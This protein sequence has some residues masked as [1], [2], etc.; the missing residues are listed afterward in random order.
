MRFTLRPARAPRSSRFPRRYK[1]PV[2]EFDYRHLHPSLFWGYEEVKLGRDQPVYIAFP[3]KALIDL[4]HL[5][6][7]IV[8]RRF[9][10]ELR[11][12]PG[13]LDAARLEQFAKRAARPKLIRAASL[14][15]RLLNDEAGQQ[16]TL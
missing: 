14:T 2:G 9:L 15:V 7:G 12:S 3:E 16:V 11:L 6:P 1:T 4:L 8:R 13:Q 5:T 10:E